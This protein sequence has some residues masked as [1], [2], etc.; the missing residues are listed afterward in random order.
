MG[1]FIGGIRVRD[2]KP[3]VREVGR[4][5]LDLA[6][7]KPGIF[8]CC[9]AITSCVT[10]GNHLASLCFLL[11]ICKT[12]IANSSLLMQLLEQG[13]ATV[14]SREGLFILI[15]IIRMS[16]LLSGAAG[17]VGAVCSRTRS[18]VKLLPELLQFGSSQ[19]PHWPSVDAFSILP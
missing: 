19:H 3:R 16:S 4:L 12:G 1:L 14:S 6:D 18:P 2:R 5:A 15:L 9:L 11:L 13:L 10:L 17:A 7:R 8:A